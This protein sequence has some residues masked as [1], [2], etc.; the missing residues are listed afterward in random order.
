MTNNSID[1]LYQN[2][3]D[4]LIDVLLGNK[5]G[6]AGRSTLW[7]ART[8]ALAHPQ[9]DRARFDHL[10]LQV[11]ETAAEHWRAKGVRRHSTEQSD[12]PDV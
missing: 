6:Y 8:T 1:V 3:K 5:E 11:H 4:A 12:R 10:V 9:F 2:F 7:K